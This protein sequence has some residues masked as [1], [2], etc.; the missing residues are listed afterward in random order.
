MK[1][2]KTGG[3]PGALGAIAR[4]FPNLELTVT[5]VTFWAGVGGH[6]YL[7]RRDYRPIQSSQPD[8]TNSTISDSLLSE[9]PSSMN[10][11]ASSSLNTAIIPVCYR[12]AADRDDRYS[13]PVSANPVYFQL[14]VLRKRFKILRVSRYL[15]SATLEYADL[16]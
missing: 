11:E 3:Y 5:F 2:D 15:H 14:D 12:M 4:L 10:R 16:L 1:T 7:S 8:A 9:W 13:V 6:K